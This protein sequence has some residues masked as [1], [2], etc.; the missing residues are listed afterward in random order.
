ML[1]P[2]KQSENHIIKPPETK[3]KKKSIHIILMLKEHLDGLQK[4]TAMRAIDCD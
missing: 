1:M 4:E 3:E 2:M